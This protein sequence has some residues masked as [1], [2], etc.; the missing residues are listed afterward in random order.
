MKVRG[1][2]GNSTV[3][4]LLAVE[5]IETELE[6]LHKAFGAEATSQVRDAAGTV[7]FAEVRIGDSVVMLDRGRGGN[8]ASHSRVYVWT[9]NVDE[10]YRLALESGATAAE[11]PVDQPYGI[12]EARIKDPAG[13]MWWIGK[14]M[15]KLSTKEIERRLME[16][17]RSRM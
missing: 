14:E 11:Q 9:D 8:E 13:N 2:Q 7:I 16:Q 5:S 15:R 10:T 6:F 3:S 4:P 1:P 17:H 12:R